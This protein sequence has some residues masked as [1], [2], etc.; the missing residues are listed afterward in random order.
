MARFTIPSDDIGKVRK[1][2]ATGRGVVMWSNQEIGNPRP[3]KITPRLSED[4]TTE[5]GKP[6]WAYDNPVVLQPS[7]IDV[8]TREPLALPPEWFPV[9]EHCHGT[10]RR[11]IASVVAAR[12][13]VTESGLAEMRESMKDHSWGPIRE[14]DTFDCNYCNPRGCGYIVKCP[15]VRFASRYWGREM[16]NTNGAQRMCERLR[17][18]YGIQSPKTVEFDAG[19]CDSEGRWFDT[20]YFAVFTVP[21]TL[22]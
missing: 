12:G 9:C 21:F 16:I 18:H 1:W 13:E 17:K 7:D 3:E 8:I 6:H 14:D 11:T 19:D 5:T 4:L 10:G 20:V 2:F 22:E 15:K